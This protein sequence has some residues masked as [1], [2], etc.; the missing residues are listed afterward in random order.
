MPP[1]ILKII[2]FDLDET[3]GYFVEIGMFW[4]ALNHY[5]GRKLSDAH[6]FETM[7]I[8]PEYLRPNIINILQYLINQK[9]AGKCDGIMIYTNNQGPKSWAVLIS[10]YLNQKLGAKIFDKIIGAFKVRGKIIEVCRKS[11]NKTYD[12]LVRCIRLPSHAQICFLDDQFHPYMKHQQIDY[13]NVKPY[14]HM[15]PFNVMAERYHSKMNL[16]ANKE[17]FIEKITKHMKLYNFSVIEK[18]KL[19]TK[20]D[21][22]VSKKMLDYLTKFFKKPRSHKR[23]KKYRRKTMKKPY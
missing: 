7:D 1:N 4:D 15:L 22:I 3:L 13:I 23:K 19:E 17:E 5:H 11:N 21:M 20:I 16:T 12:D 9:K 2:V 14:T 18:P 8:F 6:F 10:A